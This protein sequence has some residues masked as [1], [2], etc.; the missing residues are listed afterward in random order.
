MKMAN[1][2]N[3]ASSGIFTQRKIV[4]AYGIVALLPTVILYISF[5]IYY[6]G[7]A[8]YYTVKVECPTP[9]QIDPL[10]TTPPS[11]MT[12]PEYSTSSFGAIPCGHHG[13]NF[14]RRFPQVIIFGLRKGGTRA[15]IDMLSSHPK[16][17]SPREEIHFF[18]NSFEKGLQWYIEKMPCSKPDQITMEKSPSYFQTKYVA[19]RMAKTAGHWLKLILIV[20]DPVQRA[21]S[22]YVQL[23]TNKKCPEE[24]FETLA[25]YS[26]GEVNVE[27]HPIYTS[28]YDV[29]MERWLKYFKREQILIVDGD[30]LV[31]NP[32]PE[33]RKVENFL[34]V[35]PFFDDEMFFYSKTKGFY[36]MKKRDSR[37]TYVPSCLGESKGRKHPKVPD[38]FISKLKAFFKPH[39]EKFY[40][41]IGYNFDW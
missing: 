2:E 18:D 29:H 20:R 21:I 33:L 12:L 19:S 14:A 31:K 39:N 40:S 4:I 7:S 6:P 1:S 34:G 24:K 37:G 25:F 3:L 30:L 35:S 8:P 38:E 9:Q 13:S 27:F 22:D 5:H 10:L 23:V 32:L 16:I 41:L 26:N 36:C 11:A 28:M 17:V 15:L